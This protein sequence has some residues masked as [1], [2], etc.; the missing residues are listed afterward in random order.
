MALEDAVELARCLRDL[1]GRSRRRSRRTTGSAA[2]PRR[3]GSWPP[4][5]R[6]SSSKTPGRVG[7]V[8][9]DAMLR[10]VF[11]YVVTDESVAWMSDHRVRLAEPVTTRR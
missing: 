11:R 3:E 1:P 2:R 7:R 10:L 8:V 5:A 4:G 9:R 6:S